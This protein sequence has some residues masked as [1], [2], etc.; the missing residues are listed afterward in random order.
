MG[1]TS[2][3]NKSK[4]KKH[5]NNRIAGL[6]PLTREDN[7]TPI[8]AGRANARPPGSR[9]GVAQ[10]DKEPLHAYSLQ[11]RKATVSDNWGPNLEGPSDRPSQKKAAPKRRRQNLSQANVASRQMV[12]SLVNSKRMPNGRFKD[13]ISIIADE[14]FLI[15][16]Y[17]WIRGKPGN[18]TP[19]LDHETLDGIDKGFF[20]RTATDILSG[21]LGGLSPPTSFN[22]SP[23]RRK[24]IEKPGKT[25]KR[26]LGITSPRQKIVQK[27]LQMVIEAIY[28]P[29]FF[30]CSHG[31][32]P[33]RSCHSALK[34][35]QLGN[36]STF[37]WVI[38]GDIEN[39]FD[40]I[41]H[42]TIRTL[43]RKKVACERTLELIN[44]SLKA[45]YV[46]PNTGQL[47]LPH[48][49]TPQ[50]SVLSPLLSNIVLHE[51]DLFIETVLK[52]EYTKGK[53][54]RPNP[55]YKKIQ[56]KGSLRSKAEN[57]MIRHMCSKQMMDP[58]FKILKYVRYADDWVILLSSSRDD[59]VSIRSRIQR[60]LQS[61]GLALSLEKTK[62][63]H[64]RKDRCTF[65]GSIFFIRAITN[66]NIK[67][68]R[69]LQKGAKQKKTLFFSA[70][71]GANEV[72]GDSPPIAPLFAPPANKVKQRITPRLIYHA[73]IKTLLE[74]LIKNGLARRNHKGEIL[75]RAKR[76]LVPAD[77]A[78]ILAFYN[79]KVRGI[80]NYYTFV[81]NRYRL[82]SIIRYL[83]ESCALVMALK[84]KVRGRTKR[85]AFSRFG[86]R[87]VDP[88]TGRGLYIPKK[89]EMRRQIG[90]CQFRV[91]THLP[92]PDD[93]LNM[94]FGRSLTKSGLFRR[95][96]LCGSTR[97]EM[98]H[99]RS[100]KDVRTRIKKGTSSYAKYAGAF[101]RKQIGGAKPPAFG[102]L[103]P[104]HHDLY[105]NGE[106]TATDM[107]ILA[108][109]TG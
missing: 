68:M 84:Y 72:G 87:L 40:S 47:Q 70:K 20:T 57:S 109:Y 58:D 67:P 65:L 28:E 22:F 52:P 49:G 39:C 93:L 23:A 53:T 26:P 33:G 94:G 74:K 38:E 24:Y 19:G 75:A 101:Q 4:M 6:N 3:S 14:R 99:I 97:V 35:L 48:V 60:K 1:R 31:F 107:Y 89:I 66:S 76:S 36:N 88:E 96:A 102:P 69:N 9:R 62:I 45:G 56:R 42:S 51:L 46:D 79:Q 7:R 34:Q 80:L 41:P 83:H 15:A 32:R 104:Y 86:R 55:A 50:G 100:V 5:M 81:L 91:G 8:V 18:M 103:C 25:D 16:C 11:A 85:A 73:P 98:H 106:L 77:H 12:Q 54:R 95:C 82:S 29:E 63:S 78:H 13:L 2:A 59:A 30:D 90:V 64:L 10:A 71:R 27:A 105:H 44:K 21:K 92:L 37:H 61:L 108:R 17:Q 43:L